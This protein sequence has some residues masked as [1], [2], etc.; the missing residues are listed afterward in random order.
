MYR[1]SGNFGVVVERPKT[2]GRKRASWTKGMN[3]KSPFAVSGF[4]AVKS[5]PLKG[6]L[7]TVFRLL[8]NPG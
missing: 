7:D 2:Q 5:I 6:L 3:R 1:F 8:P 4:A